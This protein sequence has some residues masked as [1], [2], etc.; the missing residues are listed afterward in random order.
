MSMARVIGTSGSEIIDAADGVTNDRDIISAG[1]GDDLIFGLG[2]S[3]TILGGAGAD[4]INGGDGFDT[5]A[6]GDSD[7]GVRVDLSLGT[8]SGGTAESDT[9]ISIESVSG[10]QHDDILIAG[11]GNV[12]LGQ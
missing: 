1:A 2:G 7:E 5:A 9:L 6:Y 8:G 10:S 11:T 12:I 4:T 3:D